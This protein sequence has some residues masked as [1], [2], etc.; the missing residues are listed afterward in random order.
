[1]GSG[2]REVFDNAILQD[3]P[4]ANIRLTL[5]HNEAILKI[6]AG[7]LGMSC[8]SKLAI[9]PLSEKG[10]LVIL[11][12]PFWQLTRPLYMLVHRQK[13]QGPGLKAFLKFCDEDQA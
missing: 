7:G 6:V 3:L 1:E 4:D 9:E 11:D 13:Y 12:T 2:T 5:G 8:I 10:Q